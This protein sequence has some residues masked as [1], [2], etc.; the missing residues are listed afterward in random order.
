[1]AKAKTAA[2][3]K[4]VKAKATMTK[5][6]VKTPKKEDFPRHTKKTVRVSKMKLMPCDFCAQLFHSCDNMLFPGTVKNA[7]PDCYSLSAL[8]R[9]IKADKPEPKEDMMW[10][11]LQVEPGKEG[12][13]RTDIMRKSK[14]LGIKD[15]IGR[16]FSPLKFAEKLVQPQGEIIDQGEE[17]NPGHA[18]SICQSKVWQ[19]NRQEGHAPEAERFRYGVFQDQKTGKWCWK[20]RRILDVDPEL[21]VRKV[22]KFPGYVLINMVFNKDTDTLIKKTKYCWGVLLQTVV[23]KTFHTVLT[24]SVKYGFLWKVKDSKKKVVAKGHHDDKDG[25][26]EMAR[27]KIEELKAFQPTAMETAEAAELLIAQKAVN[28]ISK[29]KEEM[30]RAQVPFKKRD[31]VK[32]RDGVWQGTIGEVVEIIKTAGDPTARVIVTFSMLGSIL[33]LEFPHHLLTKETTN[34]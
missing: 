26:R 8:H 19:M 22:K 23:E 4:F 16:I 3:K 27:T 25:A 29:D 30:N 28:Q 7:C 9:K 32:I 33:T 13:V 24:E 1:M 34:A 2:P 11:V 15:L 5:K 6:P 18:K 10:Y 14:Q 20:I 17:D 31:K 12:K 21:V